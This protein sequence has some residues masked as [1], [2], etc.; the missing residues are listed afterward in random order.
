MKPKTNNEPK[1]LKEITEED[2]MSQKVNYVLV[3]DL[4]A[5]AVKWVKKMISEPKDFIAEDEF[6]KFFNLTEEDLQ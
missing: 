6:I 3:D 1:T 4:K 2:I 5:E